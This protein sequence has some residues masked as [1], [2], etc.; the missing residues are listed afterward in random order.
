MDDLARAFAMERRFDERLCTRMEPFSV[1]T[2]FFDEH[3]RDRFVS[4]FLCVEGDLDVTE[5]A[6]P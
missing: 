4:N 5:P 1:G 6:S 3:N 2:A